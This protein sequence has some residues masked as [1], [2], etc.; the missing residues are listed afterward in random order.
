[1]DRVL[2]ES[3]V[4]HIAQLARL[5]VTDEEIVLY[6]EQLSRILGYVEQLNEVDTRGVEP[7]AHPLPVVNVFREDSPQE[8]WSADRAMANA[9][10]HHES[11]FKLPKVL[12][13]ESA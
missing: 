11:F 13:Q 7:M 3:V 6:Q 8:S 2:D 4:R 9:P 5:K 10:D 1:M 12:D